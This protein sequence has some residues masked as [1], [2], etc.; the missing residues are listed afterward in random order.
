MSQRSSIDKLDPALKRRLI[1]LLSAPNVTQQAIADL[2]NDEAGDTVVSKSAVNRYAVRMKRFA[3]KNRQ[4][5]E[6]ADLYLD[7]YGEER[8]NRLGKVINE[9]VRMVAFDLL[10][11]LEELREEERDPKSLSNLADI[12][13]RI[14]RAIRD[15]EHAATFNAEREQGIRAAVLTEAAKAVETAGRAKGVSEEAIN[16]TK[17]KILGLGAHQ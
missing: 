6:I 17:T 7:K 5:R 13:F 4:A 16:F 9:Q 1:D 3:E 14:S 8:Q 12:I 11:N 10:M 2:I 15:L